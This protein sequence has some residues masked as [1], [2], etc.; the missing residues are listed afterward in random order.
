MLTIGRYEVLRELGRGGMATVHLARQADLGRLA[1]LKELE[2][3]R[4]TD[5]SVAQRF[6]REARMAGSLSHPNIVTVYEYFEQGGTPYIAMEY[7]DGGSLR[8][9]VAKEPSLAQIG[10]VLEG[11]LAGLDYAGRQGIVHRDLK[12]E[13]VLLTSEG[14]V[15]ITDFGISKAS[16]QVMTA[17]SLTVS[18]TTIGT[19]AYMAPEQA[20]GRP[21]SPRTD[22]YSLGVIAF[23][24]L[25]GRAPFAGT[26]TPMG[27]LLRQV[28]DPVPAVDS[29]RDDIDPRLSDWVGRLLAKEPDDRPPSAAVAS[30]ELDEILEAQLGHRWRR[31]AALPI[32]A[33]AE[34]LTAAF[35]A[36]PS[37]EPIAAPTR[38]W[39]DTHA[40]PAAGI[41]AAAG[42]GMYERTLPPA[43]P[44]AAPAP[45]PTERAHRRA[46]P[47][48]LIVAAFVL[49]A[50]LAA[51]AGT[52]GGS[53]GTPATAPAT[54]AP[55]SG[56]P[57]NP[58]NPS[59]PSNPS[60]ASNPSNPPNTNNP[61]NADS[62][63]SVGDS[64][65]S[66]SSGSDASSNATDG[67][68]GENADDGGDDGTSAANP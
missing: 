21:V 43:T 55:T 35:A 26:E 4:A 33:A 47:F 6:L 59:N 14:R 17:V 58:P 16:D 41:G 18:G 44:M 2:M 20:M 37:T 23:E 13:N 50:A 34:P 66:G 54:A 32:V 31:E 36:T 57:A 29:I 48:P 56:N 64:G 19:P 42:V 22:L 12:P 39:T 63:S 45:D 1:A 65:N 61:N 51:I 30:E 38:T 40:W 67:G 68:N 24:L 49:I 3:L 8:A 52:V 9:H 46:R 62:G 53:R 10:G 11:L 5:A 15:K 60:N 28:N 7:V 25:I 27:V